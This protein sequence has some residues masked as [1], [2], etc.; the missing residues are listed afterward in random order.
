MEGGLCVVGV[1]M[2]ALSSCMMFILLIESGI[3]KSIVVVSGGK[4]KISVM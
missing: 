1:Y 3:E 2:Y 4:E